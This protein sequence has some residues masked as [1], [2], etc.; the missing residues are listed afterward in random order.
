MNYFLIKPRV[1]KRLTMQITSVEHIK[2]IKIEYDNS[3]DSKDRDFVHEYLD[4]IYGDG[5]T[6]KR[7]GPKDH[8]GILPIGLMIIEVLIPTEDIR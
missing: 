4:D 6:I 8:S 7:S 5:Y 1:T 3:K 2:R